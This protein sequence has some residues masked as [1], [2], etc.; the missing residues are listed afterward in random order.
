MPV[1]LSFTKSEN[2]SYKHSLITVFLKKLDSR[3]CGNCKKNLYDRKLVVMSTDTKAS[4][5]II[6][7]SAFEIK[8]LITKSMQSPVDNKICQ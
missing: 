5:K 6:L 7:I 3:F 2:I 1:K 4:S 8:C